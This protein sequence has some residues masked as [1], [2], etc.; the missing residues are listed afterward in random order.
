[1]QLLLADLSKVVKEK[2]AAEEK[3]KTF[4]EEKVKIKHNLVDIIRGQKMKMEE[5][6]L[7]MKNIKKICP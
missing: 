5:D 6:K 3:A 1:M 4:E 7:K 2:M